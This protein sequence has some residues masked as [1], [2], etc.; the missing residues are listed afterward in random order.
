M[1]TDSISD[2]DFE[3]WLTEKLDALGLDAE[4]CI[5]QHTTPHPRMPQSL[6]SVITLKHPGILDTA[7]V[8]DSGTPGC[9][10]YL[11]TQYL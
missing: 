10:S 6:E 9:C 3:S 1:A 11:L 8:V 4:V 7:V 2:L 5:S